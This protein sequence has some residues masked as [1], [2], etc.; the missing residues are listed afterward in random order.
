[1]TPIRPRRSALYLPAANARAIEKARTLAADVIILDLEDSVAP[2]MKDEAR[3]MAVEAVAAGGFGPREVVIRVNGL[4]T[5]WAGSDLA[6]V[7]EAGPDGILLP[8]VASAD[9][10]ESCAEQVA[11]RA[12]LWG[13]IETCQAVF[14]LDA[15]AGASRA[16]GLDVWVI[17]ANDLVKEM[18]CRLDE[19]R[20]PLLPALS[21]AIMA[22]RAH[23]LVVLDGVYNDITNLEGLARECAQGAALG[24]DGKSLIHPSHL[25]TANRLYAP[26][27]DEVAWARTIVAA[28]AAP[29]NAGRG[30]IKVEGKM[31]ERLHLAQAERLIAVAD[32]IGARE[33]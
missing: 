21:L 16:C 29:E 25:E 33:A 4:D 10:I 15:L 19:A 6:A 18:R 26:P 1:M 30:V 31:V 14:R 23:G 3:R 32:A 5:P 7:A 2:D 24:F 17:G 9:D 20:T 13:M 27:G 22:A 28:Y 8:K 12:R 11:G